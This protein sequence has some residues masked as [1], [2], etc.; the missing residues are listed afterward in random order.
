MADTYESKYKKMRWYTER[1]R[2][3]IVTYDSKA[4]TIDDLYVNVPIGSVVR[5]YGAK[6]AD[7]FSISNDELTE[8]P[9]QYHEAIVYRAISMGYE[10][11]PNLNPEMAMYFK[12]QYEQ[13]VKAA[14]KWKKT[15]RVGGFKQLKFVDY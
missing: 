7:P 3:A 15:G 5:I 1:D 10:I 4:T 9:E 6:I 12:A 14:R 8:L 13:K 11:P 2:L